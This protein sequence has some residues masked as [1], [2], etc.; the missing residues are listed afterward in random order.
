MLM[1]MQGLL[2]PEPIAR[3]AQPADVLILW[4]PVFLM[5]GMGGVFRVG[6][7][8]PR[9]CFCC[10]RSARRFFRYRPDMAVY[11]RHAGWRWGAAMVIGFDAWIIAGA[12]AYAPTGYENF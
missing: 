6:P 1:P 8:N 7:G 4:L 5:T 12:I 9:H 11:A 3:E 10:A 2:S